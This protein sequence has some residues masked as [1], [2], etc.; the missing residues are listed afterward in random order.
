MPSLTSTLTLSFFLS[1]PAPRLHVKG[2]PCYLPLPNNRAQS[3]QWIALSWIFRIDKRGSGK[4]G[5]PVAGRSTGNGRTPDAK[6]GG[7]VDVRRL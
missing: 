6:G 1:S 3:R 5:R 2:G 4:L 7:G